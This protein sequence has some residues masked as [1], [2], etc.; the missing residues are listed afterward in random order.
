M[1]VERYPANGGKGTIEICQVDGE[2]Q[3]KVTQGSMMFHVAAPTRKDALNVAQ[4]VFLHELLKRQD[5]R[6]T[7]EHQCEVCETIAATM[8]GEEP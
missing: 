2:C 3:L 5:V 6:E 4:A 7:G 1:R 8:T